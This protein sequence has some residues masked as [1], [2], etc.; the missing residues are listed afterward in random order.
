MKEN[1]L[2]DVR[3]A[4]KVKATELAEHVGVS[5]AFISRV[6]HGTKDMSFSIAIEIADFLNVSLDEIAGR[7]IVNPKFKD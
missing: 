4:K 1:H 7:T 2:K 5:K 3:T 6:E